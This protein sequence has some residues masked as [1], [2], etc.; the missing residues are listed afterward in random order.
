[1]RH[2]STVLVLLSGLAAAQEPNT[3]P[4]FPSQV[5]LVTVDVVVL[6]AQ[7]KPVRGLRQEDFALSEDGRPQTIASFEP[8]EGG[9]EEEAPPAPRGPTVA[10]PQRS[11]AGARTFVLLV[12]DM[13]LAPQR[14]EDVRRALGRFLAD[15]LR[16]G[17][18]LIF[19]TTS[20]DAWWSARMPEGREDVTALL[21]RIRGRNLSD[22]GL[23]GVSAWEAFRIVHY[24]GVGGQALIRSDGS[25]EPDVRPT[26][27]GPSS[28]QPL[29]LPGSDLTARVTQRYYER[30]I[31]NPDPPVPT[32]LSTCIGVV[33][34][35]AFEVDQR[36]ANRTRDVLAA[37]DRAV[38]ALTGARGRKSLLLLTEGFLNDPDLREAQEVAGRCREANMVVHSIDVRGLLSGG[39]GAMDWSMPN[40]AEIGQM[41]IEQIENQA[42]GNVGL[43]EDTGGFAVANTNDLGGGA[44]RV[45]EESR[46]YYLLGFA[47]PEGKGPRDWRKLRVEVSRP[48]VRV[49]A[50]RGYTLR[51]AT[52][53]SAS[54]PSR[55]GERPRDVARAL[56]APQ[57][58]ED[59]PLRA[60]AYAFEGRPG[61]D[62]AVVVAVEADL[63]TLPNLGG[64]QSPRSVFSLSIAATH[65][66]SGKVHRVDQ[67][68]VVEA[69]LGRA[70]EGWLALQRDLELPPGVVQ[71]RV[72]LRDE[73]LGRVGAITIRFEVPEPGGLR[74]TTPILTDRLRPVPK[75]TTPAPVLLARREF[76]PSGR[77]YCQFQV[78]GAGVLARDPAGVES[79]YLLRHALGATV[80]Q[81]AIGPMTGAREGRLTSF[82]GLPLEGLAAGPYELVLSVEDRASGKTLERTE[83]FRVASG[84]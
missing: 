25:A 80:S 61:G 13:S 48:G 76:A 55:Q 74:L 40:V 21:S 7:G 12:D 42:A 27:G 52:E 22:D 33:R 38:F 17:D 51:S 69:G 81:G 49:R 71:A 84:S 19:A 68:V 67:R 70:W 36:R 54:G 30:R 10:P 34:A 41:R 77:L 57:Q 62:V 45:A 73:F 1:M 64:Q 26:L 58:R 43:A 60:R 79:R 75:G 59:I 82:F 6:D 83:A 56:L 11:R 72:V 16:D 24:E 28:I 50:R 20:G 23:D 3:V 65:R 5:E 4:S 66:D 44:V 35:K 46:V 78:L 14:A 8:F 15:G 29:A 37:V 31:C 47:P 63:A 9:A 53:V 18:E 2:I 32:P 39:L